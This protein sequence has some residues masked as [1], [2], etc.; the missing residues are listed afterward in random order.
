MLEEK[1][2]ILVTTPALKRL[3]SQQQLYSTPSRMGKSGLD[4]SKNVSLTEHLQFLL[5][6]LS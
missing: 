3:Q 4:H 5:D 6:K 1:V 2:T